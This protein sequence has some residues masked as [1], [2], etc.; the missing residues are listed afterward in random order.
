MLAKYLE[1]RPEAVRNKNVLELGAGTG[2]AGM[3]ASLL[4]AKNVLLTGE[5]HSRCVTFFFEKIR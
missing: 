3:A 4:G 1:V 2:V 5:E